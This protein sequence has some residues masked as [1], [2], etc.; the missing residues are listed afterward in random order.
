MQK[1]DD[2][3]PLSFH[4]LTVPDEGAGILRSGDGEGEH[5]RRHHQRHQRL[6]GDLL[7]QV[8][9]IQER[10]HQLGADHDPKPLLRRVRVLLEDGEGHRGAAGGRIQ[11]HEV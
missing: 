9:D 4:L 10:R 6:R 2:L 3:V 8:K 11:S 1:Q 5:G 7:R